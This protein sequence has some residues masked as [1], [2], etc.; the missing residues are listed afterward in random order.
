[1]RSFFR[2]EF[3]PQDGQ[4][5]SLDYQGQG[6]HRVVTFSPGDD[7]KKDEL[8]QSGMTPLRRENAVA[9]MLEHAYAGR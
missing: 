3:S 8:V 7:E 4:L 2:Y 1:M 6:T 5:H 9:L